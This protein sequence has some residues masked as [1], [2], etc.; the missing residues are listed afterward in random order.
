MI[1][2]LQGGFITLHQCCLA[3]QQINY[4]RHP[5]IPLRQWSVAPDNLGQSYRIVA[6]LKTNDK[7]L[8]REVINNLR[9]EPFQAVNGSL[10]PPRIER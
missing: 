10:F 8:R 1:K 7:I 3:S 6:I 9:R 2:P 4:T 5:Q